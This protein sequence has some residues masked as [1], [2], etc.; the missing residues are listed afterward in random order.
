MAQKRKKKRIGKFRGTRS[1]GTG[2]TK[3]KRGKGCKGGW[4]RAGM[5]KH[6]FSY[7]TA[8]EREWMKHGGRHG[9][10]NP[11]AKEQPA[12]NL[13]E[14]DALAKKG[15]IKGKFEFEGKILGT[16]SLSVPLEISAYLATERALERIKKAGGKFIQLAQKTQSKE[17]PEKAGE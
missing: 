2:N 3:N 13:Y 12:I 1:C 11:T 9:F 5:H 6:R 15:K 16:G 14:I 8:Y 10:S 4:G 7:A 17:A